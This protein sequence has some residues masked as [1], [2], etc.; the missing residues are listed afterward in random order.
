MTQRIVWKEEDKELRPFLVGE[1][2]KEESVIWTAQPGSQQAFLECPVYEVLYEGTRGPGK[3]DGIL[4]DYAQ[5]VGKGYGPDWRGILFRRTYPELADLIAKSK[6]LYPAIWPNAKYNESQHH[7]T[8]PDG[9][10][11][12]FAYMSKPGDYWSY[13]GHAY[14]WIGWEELCSWPSDDCYKVMMSCSRSTNPNMP[15]KYRGNTNPYGVGHNW[16]KA[17]FELPVLPGRLIGKIIKTPGHP[18]RVAIHGDLKENRVLLHADP[19]YI[20]RIRAAARND[21]ELKAW[22]YGSWDIVAGGMFD[23]VWDPK[24]HVVENI[25]PDKIPKGWRIDRSYDHGQSRPFSVGWWAESNGEPYREEG[26]LPVGYVPGDLFRIAEWYGWKQGKPNEGVRML[27]T[28]I[29]QGIVERE[30]EWG[31][32]GRVKRGPADS[33]IFDDTE[34]GQSIAGNMK[35]HGVQWDHA[36]KKAGSRKQGWE[37][38]RKLFKAAIPH[39]EKGERSEQYR[40]EPGLF[41]MERCRQFIRTIPVLPRSDKDLDDVN[42]NAEDHIGD[43]TRYR[44]RFKPKAWTKVKTR[45]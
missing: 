32:R 24:Y 7:W 29:A 11:L 22:L 5:D 10:V 15:R 20:T 3:T 17:R 25:P 43:E 1:D 40:E 39:I 35:K 8:W 9:E 45:W 23:D 31:I 36:D 38:M 28:E 12:R 4:V 34:P 41:I 18:D 14:P 6:K 33:S 13:H 2:G 37:E 21:A 16:V 26:K 19:E 30:E 42:T 44:V 27:S